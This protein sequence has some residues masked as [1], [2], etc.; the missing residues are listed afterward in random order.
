MEEYNFELF[1]QNFPDAS[2]A[3]DDLFNG[4][5]DGTTVWETSSESLESYTSSLSSL[6]WNDSGS[7]KGSDNDC[8]NSKKTK[9]DADYLKKNREAAAKSRLKRKQEQLQKSNL[10]S[11]LEN[12]LS[13]V[14]AE[15]TALQMENVSLRNEIKVLKESLSKFMVEHGTKISTVTMFG[16]ICLYPVVSSCGL[17]SHD[18]MWQIISHITVTI[19]SVAVHHM[20]GRI[21]LSNEELL[22]NTSNL[23]LPLNSNYYML[24][25]KLGYMIALCYALIRVCNML[26]NSSNSVVKSHYWKEESITRIL[27]AWTNP[28]YL[29]K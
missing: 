5:V 22:S 18:D 14:K 21:L 12:Q 7:D 15:N 6:S 9:R 10:V 8:P 24:L 11:D 27:Q 25:F 17:Y 3:L 26:F 16:V 23:L 20:S 28:T 13:M 19:P 29:P 2:S 1:D 4:G